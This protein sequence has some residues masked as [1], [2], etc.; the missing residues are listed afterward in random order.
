MKT[1]G[2]VVPPRKFYLYKWLKYALEDNSW[3]PESNLSVEVLKKHE[4]AV[5]KSGD[6]RTHHDVKCDRKAPV[7]HKRVR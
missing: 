3:K 6:M 4:D 2:L 5:V 7:A 1:E